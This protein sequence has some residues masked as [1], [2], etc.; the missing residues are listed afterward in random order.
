[1]SLNTNQVDPRQHPV[2]A[3]AMAIGAEVQGERRQPRMRHMQSANEGPVDIIAQVSGA[4]P[5]GKREVD[6]ACIIGNEGIPFPD[7]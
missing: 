4:S 2:R 5:S 7:P 6:G 1:M 3:M